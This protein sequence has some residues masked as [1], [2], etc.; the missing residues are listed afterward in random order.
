MQTRK[1]TLIQGAAAEP[2]GFIHAIVKVPIAM[3]AGW[4]YDAAC[5]RLPVSFQT[6]IGEPGHTQTT[7]AKATPRRQLV[8]YLGVRFSVKREKGFQ[9]LVEQ[10]I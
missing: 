10:V 1:E 2:S 9:R 5:H 4:R 7:N 3:N 6:L 8:V